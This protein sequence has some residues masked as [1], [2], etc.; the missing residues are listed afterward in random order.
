ML[1]NKNLLHIKIIYKKILC[2]RFSCSLNFIT[3]EV[4]L[5]VQLLCN[6]KERPRNLY[7]KVN[8]KLDQEIA[9]FPGTESLLY[10]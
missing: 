4:L 8:L 3:F 2:F 10:E 5:N 7:G 9:L 6:T 1:R